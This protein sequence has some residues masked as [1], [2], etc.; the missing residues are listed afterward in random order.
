MNLLPVPSEVKSHLKAVLG[1]PVSQKAGFWSLKGMS[2]ENR[3]EARCCQWPRVSSRAVSISLVLYTI[4]TCRPSEAGPFLPFSEVC[5]SH[6]SLELKGSVL[7]LSAKRNAKMS[8]LMGTQ[9]DCGCCP[10]WGN[11]LPRNVNKTLGGYYARLNLFIKGPLQ[12]SFLMKLGHLQ[13][14]HTP[15]EN[16]VRN[17]GRENSF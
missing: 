5:R 3:A 2:K 13:T 7:H 12:H 9:D 15:R 10:H 1:L 16:R 6:S 17:W 4:V 14:F 11:I 8:F